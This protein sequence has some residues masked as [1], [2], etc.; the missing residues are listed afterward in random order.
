M[1]FPNFNILLLPGAQVGD[2]RPFLPVKGWYDLIVLFI[3][4]KE[5]PTGKSQTLANNISDL[6]VA[7]SEVALRVF[8]IE[9]PSRLDIRDQ[10]EALN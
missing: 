3:G 2:V 1:T 5:L 10:A 8:V 6:T 9:V 7:A 4:G